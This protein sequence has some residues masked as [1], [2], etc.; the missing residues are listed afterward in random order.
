MV[1]DELAFANSLLLVSRYSTLGP[2]RAA[3]CR[4]HTALESYDH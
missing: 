4:K 2:R 1:D 3:H